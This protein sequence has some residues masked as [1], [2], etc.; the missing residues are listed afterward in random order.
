MAPGQH[1]APA[2]PPTPL[3][4]TRKEFYELSALCR[5]YATELAGRDPRRIHLAESRRMNTWLRQL[6]R[7]ERLGPRIA[8]IK[9]ARPIARWQVATLTGVLW[10]LLYLY[11]ATRGAQMTAILILNG[12][13]LLILAFYMI[14]ERVFGTTIE[15]LEGKLL[16]VVEALEEMLVAGEMGFSEAAY[17]Q[18]RD[19]LAAA[20]AELRQQIDLAHRE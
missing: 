14:P 7:H 4:F 17:F 11:A 20:H 1:A 9:A 3:P 16:R 2:A 13:I 6:K 19:N 15:G 10:L 18:A 5:D 12:S 8:D